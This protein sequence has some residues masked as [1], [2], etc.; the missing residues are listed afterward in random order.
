MSK[1]R[2]KTIEEFKECGDWVNYHNG[3]EG[4]SHWNDQGKMNEF[5]GQDIPD[6]FNETIDGGYDFSYG[7]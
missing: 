3:H 1:Y 6:E 2:F 4:P 7:N 5:Y